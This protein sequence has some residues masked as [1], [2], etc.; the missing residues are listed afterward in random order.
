MNG[1]LSSDTPTKWVLLTVRVRKQL[2]RR[3]TLDSSLS[4]NHRIVTIVVQFGSY[5]V[6]YM[7]VDFD[8][9]V[10]VF[11]KQRGVM[12][13]PGDEAFPTGCSILELEDVDDL[14]AESCGRSHATLKTSSNYSICAAA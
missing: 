7:W 8:N 10:L 11:V 13:R 4:S 9:Y 3:R 2:K 6:V 5:Q 1:H 14:R 12:H